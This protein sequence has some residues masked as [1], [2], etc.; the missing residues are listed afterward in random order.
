VVRPISCSQSAR[1]QFSAKPPVAEIS[2][3][4]NI[5]EINPSERPT[6]KLPGEHNTKNCY[7]HHCQDLAIGAF[8]A[9]CMALAKPRSHSRTSEVLIDKPIYQVFVPCVPEVAP[10]GHSTV[11][12]LGARAIAGRVVWR[13]HLVLEKTS[14]NNCNCSVIVRRLSARRNARTVRQPH[15]VGDCTCTYVVQVGTARRRE[16][17]VALWHCVVYHLWVKLQEPVRGLWIR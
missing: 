9:C 13:L 12:R 4:R 14:I 16:T 5:P 7:Q 10:T 15:Q 17:V 11:T 3:S 8:Q 1:T 6:E 2:S